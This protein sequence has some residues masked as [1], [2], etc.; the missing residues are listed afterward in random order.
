MIRPL[1]PEDSSTVSQLLFE[2]YQNMNNDLDFDEALDTYPNFHQKFLQITTLPHHYHF[3]YLKNNQIIGYYFLAEI[4]FPSKIIFDSEKM[5][6]LGIILVDPPHQ[7]SG[8]GS[9]LL[10][11]AKAQALTLG[12]QELNL[13]VLSHSE[14][15]LRFYEKHQFI[16]YTKHLICDLT[17]EN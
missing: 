12:Y 2:M 16:E 8:I 11:H 9:N 1:L 5:C 13:E 17:E 6:Y 15:N 4:N 14:K 3:I 7:K 10:I